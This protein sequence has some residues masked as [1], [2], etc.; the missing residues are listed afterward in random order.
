MAL[1]LW[2]PKD[3]DSVVDYG[4]DWTPRLSGDTIADSEWIIEEAIIE[5][6]ASI[7][8][9]SEEF[10]ATAAMIWLSGGAAGEK[11]IITNRVTTVGGRI[12][13]QSVQLRIKDL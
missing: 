1:I 11:H 6:E 8:I 4:L 9:E 7:E 12:F 13:D 2:P 5:E 3:P 10:S